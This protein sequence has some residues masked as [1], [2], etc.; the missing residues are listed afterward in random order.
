M[1]LRIA[2]EELLARVH[3]VRLAEGAEPIRFH[4]VLNR[5]PRGRADRVHSR[6]GSA[7]S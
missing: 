4:S 1:N 2:L 5:S 6:V 7:G 3:D